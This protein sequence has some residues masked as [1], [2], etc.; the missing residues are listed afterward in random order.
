MEPDEAL[1]ELGVQRDVHEVR[2]SSTIS[3]DK[4]TLVQ[5]QLASASPATQP[6][7][8]ALLKYI[9]NVSLRYSAAFR[10]LITRDVLQIILYKDEPTHKT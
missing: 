4:E 2:F 10:P 1:V 6:P 5:L 7:R 8:A 9:E 3:V